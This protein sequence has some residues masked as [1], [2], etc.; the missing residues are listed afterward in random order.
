MI[1][2][3]LCILNFIKKYPFLIDLLIAVIGALYGGIYLHGAI[4]RRSEAKYGFYIG[5]LQFITQLETILYKNKA[6]IQLMA[7]PDTLLTSIE[8]TG[9]IRTGFRELSGEFL[10]FLNSSKDII[11]PFRYKKGIWY[12]NLLVIVTFLQWGAM[13]GDFHPVDDESDVREALERE[14]K[15]IFDALNQTECI[16][17]KVIGIK[18]KE[19]ACPEVC[20][21]GQNMVE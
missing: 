10:S 12:N 11:P 19:R 20:V 1:R 7:K 18:K 9:E 6:I 13:A 21:N 8:P 14:S 2:G 15:S 16:L 4:K 5:Y 17:K 3:I